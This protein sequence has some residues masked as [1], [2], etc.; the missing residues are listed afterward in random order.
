[1]NTQTACKVCVAG[2]ALTEQSVLGREKNI[3]TSPIAPPCSHGTANQRQ[4]AVVGWET[5][6]NR[7]LNKQ[8]GEGGEG[9]GRK[10]NNKETEGKRKCKVARSCF[11][12]R[13]EF[14][15]NLAYG[16]RERARGREKIYLLKLST[17]L[18][19]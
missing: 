11:S 10:G 1:M 3:T 2:S 7:E 14:L 8:R 19:A 12:S 16:K 9:G 17:F 6:E 18:F 5:S 13:T 15:I 4:A